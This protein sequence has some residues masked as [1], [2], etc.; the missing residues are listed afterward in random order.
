MTRF[1]MLLLLVVATLC[2]ASTAQVTAGTS[3]GGL[4]TCGSIK[5]KGVWHRVILE[6]EVRF[7]NGA[8]LYARRLSVR[9]LKYR[10]APMG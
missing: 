7:R 3:L 10:S 1:A 5:A 4:R 2:V 8:C 6:Q 9:C